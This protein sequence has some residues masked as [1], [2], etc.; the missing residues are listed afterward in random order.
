MLQ[1]YGHKKMISDDQE[2]KWTNLVNVG[3]LVL[4]GLILSIMF[5]IITM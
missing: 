4:V 1:K 3:L 2:I 5:L